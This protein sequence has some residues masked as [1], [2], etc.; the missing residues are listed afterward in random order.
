MSI[1][2]K[3]IELLK[4][5][6]KR[7]AKK[8]EKML[9]EVEEEFGDSEFVVDYVDKEKIEKGT[10]TDN[11]DSNN[12]PDFKIDYVA[13]SDKKFADAVIEEEEVEIKHPEPIEK[14]EVVELEIEHPEPIKEKKNKKNV[15]KTL[16]RKIKS[17]ANRVGN[18]IKYGAVSALGATKWLAHNAGKGIKAVGAGFKKGTSKVL[19]GA[20]N[21]FGTIKNKLNN[22]FGNF[23]DY[24]A[25]GM[26]ALALG[27]FA[28]VGLSSSGIISLLAGI[29][30]TITGVATIV[31]IKTSID[32][33][34][35]E[36]KTKEEITDEDELELEEEEKEEELPKAKIKSYSLNKKGL[37]IKN[38]DLS[39]IHTKPGLYIE[40][41]YFEFNDNESIKN[42]IT[43]KED[44]EV[45]RYLED[46]IE[47]ITGEVAVSTEFTDKK[48]NQKKVYVLTR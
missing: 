23:K 40:P 9:R 22:T 17:T 32:K 33:I 47:E 41:K 25:V 36:K 12:K 13:V 31:N 10:E 28:I 5:N 30:L 20:K 15:L 6:Q 21:L 7:L 2:K 16:G 4:W 18:T 3:Y 29:G 45:N 42:F 48:Q 38:I 39:N 1:R 24:L 46:T 11:K 8:E 43:N 26:N 35:E 34:K 27:I 19:T 14:E 44:E 37:K